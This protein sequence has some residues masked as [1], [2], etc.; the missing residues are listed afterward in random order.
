[1]HV[2]QPLL[3]LHLGADDQ[4]EQAGG[5]STLHYL[6]EIRGGLST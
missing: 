1:M 4:V 6:K 2:V 3:L 5:V